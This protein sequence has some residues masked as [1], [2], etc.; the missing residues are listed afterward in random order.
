MVAMEITVNH[1]FL[2]FLV[3]W[4]VQKLQKVTNIQNFSIF[5]NNIFF[6]S[7]SCVVYNWNRYAIFCNIDNIR[8]LSI[9]IEHV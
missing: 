5:V 1:Y 6:F 3:F 8:I 9:C 4:Q 7:F 2:R